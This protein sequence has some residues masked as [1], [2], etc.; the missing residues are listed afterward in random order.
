MRILFVAQNYREEDEPGSARRVQHAKALRA[1]GHHVT[2][3]ASFLPYTTRVV[4]PAYAGRRIVAEQ[5]HGGPA[6][7]VWSRPY[8][9]RLWSRMANYL[10]FCALALVAGLRA[11]RDAGG[12]DLV[13]AHST[14]LFVGPVGWL[15]ARRYRAAFLFECADLWPDAPVSLGLLAADSPFVRAAFALEAWCF[16][17]A[18]RLVGIS[19]SMSEM[20]REKAHSDGGGPPVDTVPNGYDAHVFDGAD[21]ARLPD[22]A[23]PPG[24][25]SFMF[26]GT[27]GLNNGLE[28]LV[29]AAALLRDAGR[30]DVRLTFVGT[31]AAR[32][33][34]IKRARSL[35][36]GEDRVRFYGP[37]PRAQVGDAVAHADAMVRGGRRSHYHR[38]GLAN[39]FFDNLAAGVPV[40]CP[41]GREL[42]DHVVRAR[43]GVVYRAED[44]ADLAR[45]LGEVLDLPAD[46][47]AAMGARG[48]AYV[49]THFD[50]RILTNRLERICRATVADRIRTLN[51]RELVA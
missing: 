16:A 2:V 10:S 3:V 21:A 46:E 19:E 44:P 41:D 24:V 47:R 37:V 14:P 39:T 11:R 42:T 31:G 8:T 4:P 6:W 51:A 17:R 5:R 13:M 38:V 49:I 15:L 20:M 43:C 48:K 30:D 18:D 28:H 1:A 36:L 40:V 7:M 22:L 50:R 45:A 25:F 23:A 12:F 29:D 35:G 9:D 26:L 32:D 33:G 34:L 27:H